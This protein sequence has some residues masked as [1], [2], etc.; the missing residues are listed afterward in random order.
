MKNCF[1][2]QNFTETAQS[3]AELWPKII[4]NMAAVSHFE[5]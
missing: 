5:I 2:T 4:F 1:T 3:A